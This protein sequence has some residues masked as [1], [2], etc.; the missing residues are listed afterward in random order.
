MLFTVI[1]INY[2][3]KIGLCQTIESVL[4][5]TY[6]D[7]EYVVIDGG[8]SDGSVEVISHFQERISYWVSEK[9]RGIYHAM[10]KGVIQAHGEY[11]I[12]INS[13]DCFYNESVLEQVFQKK[14][15]D[16]IIVGKVSIDEFDHLVSP[17]PRG[18][19]TFYHLY[20]GAIPHQGSFIRTSL[21]RMFPYD[22]N[23]KIS[24]D[25]KFFVQ[26]LV[27]NNCSVLYLDFFVARYD[28]N[29]LSSSNPELMRKEKD[30]VLADLFPPRVLADY[31]RMK[32]SECLTQYLTPLL[33]IHYGID[34]VV[35]K[36]GKILLKIRNMIS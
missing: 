8:S 32:Q 28:L 7:F 21:L 12:F 23:L 22:E 27:L 30:E 36:I 25:W 35:Y 2:N 26:T 29:G 1:T 34:K 11:C 5:Q 18:D 16:D 15:I 3:N 33:K 13:G 24:S 19:L 9:D 17:P 20:S 31:L 14:A 10:N 6:K 4:G